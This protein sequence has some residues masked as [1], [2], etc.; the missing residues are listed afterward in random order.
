MGLP[1]LISVMS[2]FVRGES[3]KV[4][5]ISL[6]LANLQLLVH[7][8]EE[9]PADTGVDS[10]LKLFRRTDVQ[11][12]TAFAFTSLESLSKWCTQVGR[13]S[14][15]VSLL[16]ADLAAALPENTWLCIDAAEPHALVFKPE[17]LA[18]VA[19]NEVVFEETLSPTAPDPK[20]QQPVAKASDEGGDKP[21]ESPVRKPFARSTPTQFFKREG[22][23][24]RPPEPLQ[25]SRQRT[26]TQ[27]NLKKI[28]R[29]GGN[30]GG[31][32]EPEK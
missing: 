14:F 17:Y 1:D 19:E 26:F 25:P 32:G 29:P 15:H 16:G 11:N 12:A 21:K 4:A 24:Q 9:L 28:I 13:P 8:S 10:K 23:S 27:S 2:S 18:R 7:L 22:L 6:E 31:D 20:L 5:S 30:N 3:S